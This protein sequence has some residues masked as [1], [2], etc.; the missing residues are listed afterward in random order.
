MTPGRFNR[1][2]YD[3]THCR[4]KSGASAFNELYRYLLPKI[5]EHITAK[6]GNKDIAMD[7]A[8]DFFTNRQVATCVTKSMKKTCFFR[9]QVF[10][11][12][13]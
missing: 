5:V 4:D 2:I 6:Y 10:L 7:I 11:L 12:A 8:H 13:L 3:F 9:K 1:L